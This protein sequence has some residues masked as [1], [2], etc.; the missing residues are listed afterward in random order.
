MLDVPRV[1]E[2]KEFFSIRG[3][4]RERGARETA[5]CR[6]ELGPFEATC[7]VPGDIAINNAKG[8]LFGFNW[9]FSPNWLIGGE[10]DW[11]TGAIQ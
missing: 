11:E 10:V 1:W 4:Q 6:G 8:A 5:Q 9:Q 3:W 7:E 2:N